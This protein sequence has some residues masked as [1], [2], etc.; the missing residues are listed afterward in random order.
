MCV[1]CSDERSHLDSD[2]LVRPCALR[3]NVQNCSFCSLFESCD[4]LRSRA[5]ILDETKKKFTSK[6]SQDAYELFF[7]PYEGREE[8]RKQRKKR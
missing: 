3:N 6:I 8:L 2:C 7:R 4:V 1:G 5:D